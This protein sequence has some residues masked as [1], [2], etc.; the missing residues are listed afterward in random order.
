[1][2][3]KPPGAGSACAESA[4]IDVERFEVNIGDSDM[5]IRI[6]QHSDCFEVRAK[7]F[8]EYLEDSDEFFEDISAARKHF[9]S[10]VME[11]LKNRSE[12]LARLNEDDL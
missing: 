8:F 11:W 12:I 5:V 1:M 10:L 2:K 3:T 6:V 9:D 4:P 7:S